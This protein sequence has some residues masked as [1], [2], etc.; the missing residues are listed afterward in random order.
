M[1]YTTRYYYK[2]TTKRQC[3]HS[4]KFSRSL[5]ME[6]SIETKSHKPSHDSFLVFIYEN[7]P[8]LSQTFV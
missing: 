8:V 3:P 7:M 5:V 6:I 2:N 1:C 4:D